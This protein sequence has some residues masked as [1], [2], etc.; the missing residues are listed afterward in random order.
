M[1]EEERRQRLREL[2]YDPEKYDLLTPL[3]SAQRRTTMGSAALTGVKQSVGPMAGGAAGALLGAKVGFAGGGPIGALAGSLVGGIVGGFGGGAVQSAVEE[4]ALDEA[5]QAA[6]MLERQAAAQKYPYTTFFSQVAPSLLLVRPDPRQ[7]MALPGAIKNAPLRTQ[8]A[9]EK[10][11]LT[12]AGIS[13]GLEAGVEAGTQAI[14]GGEMDYRRIALAGLVGGTLT[15][16]WLLGKRIYGSAEAPLP[17]KVKVRDAEG[18]VQ[19]IN[20]PALMEQLAAT[21]SRV[22]EEKEASAAE[23]QLELDIQAKEAEQAANDSARADAETAKR[24]ETTASEDKESARLLKEEGITLNR[25]FEAAQKKQKA[26]EKETEAL[27]QQ[28]GSDHILVR[29]KQTEALKALED[30]VTVRERILEHNRA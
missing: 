25:E 14:R 15:Q 30:V 12:N 5:D 3:E 17:D 6:L 11:A 27:R 4:A 13:S 21:R 7:L 26:L 8:S 24:D 28:H 16:P 10:Y 29:N 22:F 23:K 9:L 1:T 18:N 19:E 20:N 2:G